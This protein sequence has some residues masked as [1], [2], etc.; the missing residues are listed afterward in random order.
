M[1]IQRFIKERFAA[2]GLEEP[3][4]R[5]VGELFQSAE[6]NAR[7]R[8]RIEAEQRARE[9]MRREQEAAK[10]REK[11]LDGLAGKETKKWAEVE[12]LISTKQPRCYDLAV[13]LI[14]DLRDLA[15]RAKGAEFHRSLEA[16]RQAHA[17]KPSFLERL[18]KAG[19]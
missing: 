6:T 9:K 10:K 14:I 19:L 18:K 7:E 1:L 11:Y 2:S 8:E 12:Q 5:K 13:N 16:L 15:L 17:R 3:P 4:R